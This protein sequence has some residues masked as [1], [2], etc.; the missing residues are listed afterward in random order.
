[1][2]SA[3]PPPPKF[4]WPL[5]VLATGVALSPLL[6]FVGLPTLIFFSSQG[7]G[8]RGAVVYQRIE[9]GTS[10][11]EL[12]AQL[13]SAGVKFHSGPSGATKEYSHR[14]GPVGIAIYAVRDGYVSSKAVD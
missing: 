1:M 8:N 13:T 10:E 14:H 2:M 9:V 12:V 5:A 4:S 3:A 11:S 6:L 7:E